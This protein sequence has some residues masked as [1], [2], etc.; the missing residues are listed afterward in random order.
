MQ[1]I[2][3]RPKRNF[4]KVALF[5][6]IVIGC[7][8][9]FASVYAPQTANVTQDEAAPAAALSAKELARLGARIYNNKGA[10]ALCHE[11]SGT[12]AP[13]LDAV[14]G[15]FAERIKEPLYKGFAKNIDEYIVESMLRPSVY[16]VKGYG[17]K[18]SNDTVSPM[19]DVSKEPIGLTGAEVRAVVEFL[20]S[21]AGVNTD[22]GKK[23][24]ENV[25]TR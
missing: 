16:V 14:A 12:R 9:L 22:G 6:L 20:K 18:G 15:V 3:L 17:A 2:E 4:A 8:T 13:R 24:D 1:E 7:Y 21:R 10:C 11:G 19:P 5:S 25:E 23:R